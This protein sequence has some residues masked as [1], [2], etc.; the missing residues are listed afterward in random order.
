MIIKQ[1][2]ATPAVIYSLTVTESRSKIISF[3]LPYV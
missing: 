1:T 2:A 3:S